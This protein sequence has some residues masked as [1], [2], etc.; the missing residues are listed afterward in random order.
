V[1]TQWYYSRNGS[2]HGPVAGAELRALAVAGKLLPT[3][4]VWKEGMALWQPASKVKGLFQQVAKVPPPPP[5]RLLAAHELSGTPLPD[6]SLSGLA[7]ELNTTFATAGTTRRSADRP[8]SNV[9]PELAACQQ[10]EILR[11]L[12][13]GGMG[14]VYLARN[15]RMD[16]Q[17]ALKV[18]DKSLLER[19]GAVERFLREIRS[20]AQLSHPNVVT[21][22]SVLESE[23]LLALAM[24]Y[25]EGRNLHELVK[26]KGPLS[27]AN[28][29]YYVQQAALGLQ[30]A[31]ERGMVHRDVKPHNLILACGGKKHLVKVLDFGLAK[32]KRDGPGA[33][34]T[35]A[36]QM[37]GTPDFVAP[38]QVRDAAAA[39]IRADIYGLGCTLY[40]LLTGAPPFR[41]RGLFEILE[42][43]Q[44]AVARP[45]DEARPGVPRELATVVAKMMAK[46]P[47]D[48]YQTP[49][50]AAQA[51][52]LISYGGPGSCRATASMLIG[53]E[54]SS[55]PDRI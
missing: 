29:C 24:E 6:K 7:R 3:D 39:D 26:A 51:L 30:H 35:A 45:L 44:R 18:V 21:A 22:Y 34:L 31:Y 17:E 23:G 40:Y 27:V 4:L 12:G 37:L 38:E 2:N 9:P 47:T 13:R 5:G 53:A 14:I 25:V 33:A 28:A 15:K 36:G 46:S 8:P 10:Y 50:E 1:A 20:A 48:R 41:G 43:H 16:R 52:A 54:L 42:A 11:E 32:A 19:P 49:V 55:G